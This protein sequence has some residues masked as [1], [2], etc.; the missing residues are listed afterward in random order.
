MR[1]MPQPITISEEIEQRLS[2]VAQQTGQPVSQ[3]LEQALVEYLS[4]QEAA[5][6]ALR[7]AESPGR[8]IP[9]DEI[10]HELELDG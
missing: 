8:M 3:H 1:A 4:E 7:R 9:F 5:F 10:E 2:R 6:V